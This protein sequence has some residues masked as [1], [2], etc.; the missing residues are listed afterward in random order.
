MANGPAHPQ[1]KLDI[2]HPRGLVPSAVASEVPES[3]FTSSPM[4]LSEQTVYRRS[5]WVN[6]EVLFRVL[7]VVASYQLHTTVRAAYPRRLPALTCLGLRELYTLIGLAS[8]CEAAADVYKQALT[9]DEDLLLVY[10]KLHNIAVSGSSAVDNIALN[11]GRHGPVQPRLYELSIY[12]MPNLESL[13]QSAPWKIPY[14]YMAWCHRRMWY[15]QIAFDESMLLMLQYTD[16]NNSARHFETTRDYFICM[17]YLARLRSTRLSKTLQ[18]S[19][20]IKAS[21]Y[22]LRE[23]APYP[24]AALAL[25]VPFAMLA[26]SSRVALF[27]RPLNG[28]QRLLF[29]ATLYLA[30]M[31]RYHHF[32]YLHSLRDRKGAADA[33][34][35][36][37][38]EKP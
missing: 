31:Q 17:T 18:E 29:G 15:S 27:F 11:P 9:T 22:D 6:L 20:G 7:S 34:L 35:V 12:R 33:L 25:S 36:E 1:N 4:R 38:R 37:P 23:Y 19:Y 8:T 3:D 24:L 14:D 13:L 21:W 2:Y 10:G 16:T 26:R 30:T 5:P 32:S 28:L